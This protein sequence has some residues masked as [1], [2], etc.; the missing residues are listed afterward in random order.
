MCG[1]GSNATF[2]YFKVASRQWHGHSHVAHFAEGS[3]QSELGMGRLNWSTWELLERSL[4]TS[5]NAVKV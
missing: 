1:G 5:A 4:I 2:K 3:D